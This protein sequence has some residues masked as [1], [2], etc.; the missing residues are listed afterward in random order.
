MLSIIGKNVLYF[1]VEMH[2]FLEDQGDWVMCESVVGLD[3]PLSAPFH[4]PHLF[5]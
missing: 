4:G 2:N 3:F 5:L 1:I